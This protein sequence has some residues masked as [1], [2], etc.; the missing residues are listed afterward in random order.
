MVAAGLSLNL[1]VLLCLG[2]FFCF[3]FALPSLKM[4]RDRERK[5][6]H[7][8]ATRTPEQHLL[9]AIGQKDLEEVRRLLEQGV[10]SNATHQ[11]GRRALHHAI[12]YGTAEIV[13]CLLEHGATDDPE[14]PMALHLAATFG[15]IEM[16]KILVE[17]GWDPNLG[18]DYLEN[19]RLISPLDRAISASKTGRN[20][21]AEIRYLLGLTGGETN[22]AEQGDARDSPPPRR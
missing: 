18:I 1:G 13:K 8:L 7:Y 11:S 15:N 2:L 12:L 19:G 3:A 14:T 6:A 16:L 9:D 20:R 4:K 10:D 17:N 21:E 22:G 5:R